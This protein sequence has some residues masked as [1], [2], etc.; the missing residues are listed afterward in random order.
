M[1]FTYDS[2]LDWLAR[3]LEENGHRPVRP[4]GEEQAP[5]PGSVL[6]AATIYFD[7]HR[8]SPI[9]ADVVEFSLSEARLVIHTSQAPREG[10]GCRMAI[11]L[12][13]PRAFLLQGRLGAVRMHRIL[14]TATVSL[15]GGL[16]NQ[17]FMGEAAA[18]A[19]P[20]PKRL[21][22]PAR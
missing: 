5:T 15:A 3:L 8:Q 6:P 16:G 22:H 11:V 13:G 2:D 12:P 21:P 9:R 7:D 14:N 1:K 18:T 17:P 4:T 19:A 10:L 20:P